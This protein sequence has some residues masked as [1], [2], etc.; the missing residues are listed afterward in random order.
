MKA[1]QASSLDDIESS[2]IS[3]TCK[4]REEL[5]GEQYCVSFIRWTSRKKEGID[6]NGRVGWDRGGGQ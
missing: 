4:E 6:I 5:W 2:K 3:S 1:G